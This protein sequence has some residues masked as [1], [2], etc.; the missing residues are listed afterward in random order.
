[1]TKSVSSD[2][3]QFSDAV[4]IWQRQ[5]G[6][7]QLPW[8]CKDPYR[9]WVSEIMLQQTQVDT[10]I[11][12][13]NRFMTA[14]PTV[15]DLAKA[16]FDQVSALWSGLGYYARARN[17]HKAAMQIMSEHGGQFP[18]EATALAALPGIGRSTASAISVFAFGHREAILD[19]NVKRVLTRVFAVDAP[20]ETT[21]TTALLWQKAVELLPN[22]HIESYTQ[23]LMDLGASLCSRTDP[24]CL[25]CP[26]VSF[27]E[28]AKAGNPEH[29]P[30]KKTKPI[31]PT[32]ETAFLI[33]RQ[34][35]HVYLEKRP[36]KGVWGKLWAFPE[37]GVET[38][39]KD[40]HII[41]ETKT[42][43]NIKASKIT[44]LPA[45]LHTFTHFHLKIEPILI[46]VEKT[47]NDL[48]P[49]RWV[50]HEECDAYGL[51]KPVKDLWKSIFTENNAEL[52]AK[53]CNKSR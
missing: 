16:E 13:F 9:I 15:N 31:K 53:K 22:K 46:D 48:L 36:E 18:K 30:V 8:Q 29:Y 52:L 24:K 50:I 42:R 11:G 27:C 7:H 4:V 5:F 41:K 1:M 19:G 14:F 21:Q 43:F 49:G 17:L 47:Q 33:L 26:V 35:E 28:A 40:R 51:P 38:V 37:C 39:Q 44:R 12:Y 25:V 2:N 23:G 3:L 32:R 10:V 6:R 34:N 45:V 20:L